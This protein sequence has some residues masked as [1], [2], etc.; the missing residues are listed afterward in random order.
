M[1]DELE[2]IYT[3]PLTHAKHGKSSKRA[4]RAVKDVR[5]FLTRHMKSSDIWLAGE[6]NEA[7]WARG[8]YTIPSKIRVRATRFADGVVEVTLPDSTVEGS[9]REAIQERIEKAAETP[10]LAPI[11]MD[12]EEEES[13]QAAEPVTVIEGIGPATAE[14]LEK[15]EIETI[16]D[17][18][19]ADVAAVAAATGK[20]EE[21]AKAWIDAAHA[22]LGHSHDEEE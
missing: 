21:V 15:I 16:G 10:V 1:A 13:P 14:K 3:I 4:D 5:T 9:M 11:A 12:G 18:G 22:M 2:R 19:H 17:L 20:S 6:V 8:K 7:I